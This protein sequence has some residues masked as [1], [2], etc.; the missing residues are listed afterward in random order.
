MLRDSA[1]AV[2]SGAALRSRP[3]RSRPA[4]SSRCTRPAASRS[5][6]A[7][8]GMVH[9]ARR[10]NCCRARRCGTCWARM[11][12]MAASGIAPAATSIRSRW[13]GGWRRRAR[14]RRPHLCALAGAK[15]EPRRSLGGEDGRR[16]DP[17]PRAGCG[18]QCLYGEIPNRWC[19]N[20]HGSGAGS[21]L[22]DG[23]PAAVRQYPKDHHSRPA[24]D[25]GHPWRAIFRALRCRTVSSPAAR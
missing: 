20:R 2:R 25:V 24:G 14:P 8:S 22:A 4:G 10:S 21:V 17:G 13:R 7:A 18:D 15:L 1:A 12:G 9:A 16:R 23:D 11:P 19:R 5:P 3:S 6:N